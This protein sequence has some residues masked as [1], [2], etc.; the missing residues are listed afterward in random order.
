MAG[1]KK[2]LLLL[3]SLDSQQRV[4]RLRLIWMRFRGTRRD[5][6]RSAEG[7]HKVLFIC[8]G[9]IMRSAFAEAK[10]RSMVSSDSSLPRVQSASAGVFATSG[11]RPD[12]RTKELASEHGVSLEE[13]AARP[14][15]GLDVVGSDLICVMDALSETICISRFPKSEEKVV[16]LGAFG[17]FAGEPLDIADPFGG[18]AETVR[19]C[20]ARVDRSVKALLDLLRRRL[21]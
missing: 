9:N 14:L 8:H 11:R 17:R 6:V 15:S 19:S 10:L 5:T 16:M 21:P 18:N 20:F 3:R 4:L 7:I 1:V 2:E 13:H 12:G